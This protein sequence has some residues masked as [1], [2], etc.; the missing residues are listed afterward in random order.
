MATQNNSILSLPLATFGANAI[1]KI[2]MNNHH[3]FTDIFL[4]K[5]VL[6]Q[7]NITIVI[8][9]YCNRDQV[10][11]INKQQLDLRI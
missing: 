5:I 11:M 8:V 6:Q 1:Q 7:Y 10:L 4:I 9:Q 2:K 3:S